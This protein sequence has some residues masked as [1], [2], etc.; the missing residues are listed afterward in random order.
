M[1]NTA[2]TTVT[3]KSSPSTKLVIFSLRY[4]IKS[5]FMILFSTLIF[6]FWSHQTLFI[7]FSA[8]LEWQMWSAAAIA[9]SK[10]CES[11]SLCEIRAI[12]SAILWVPFP[13]RQCLFHQMKWHILA[14]AYSNK[15]YRKVF[16][17]CKSTNIWLI[18]CRMNVLVL[19]WAHFNLSA[20]STALMSW[21]I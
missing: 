1:T 13:F 16:K 19:S 7:R 4:N 8:S 11:Q 15:K 20:H 14:Q 17:V 3:H 5:K 9:S 12:F 10:R 18:L 2:T 21:V 6:T